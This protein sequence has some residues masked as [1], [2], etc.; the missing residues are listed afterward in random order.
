MQ[1]DLLNRGLKFKEAK[2]DYTEQ[3]KKLEKRIM[4]TMQALIR[5]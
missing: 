1:Q 3:R 5:K 4:E 2:R